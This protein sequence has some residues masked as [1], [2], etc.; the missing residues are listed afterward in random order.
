MLKHIHIMEKLEKTMAVFHGREVKVNRRAFIY[1][2][3]FVK[4]YFIF[5]ETFL[6]VFISLISAKIK[7][8]LCSLQKFGFY[9]RSFFII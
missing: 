1:I 5:E 6:F 2:H 7:H 9:F 4:A 8:S 3:S